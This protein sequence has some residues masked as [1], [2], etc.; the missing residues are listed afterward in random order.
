MQAT[1]WVRP[2]PPA[3]P[4]P[5]ALSN[6]LELVDAE[7]ANHDDS[8]NGHLAKG[9]HKQAEARAALVQA[10]D[11]NLAA[12]GTPKWGLLGDTVDQV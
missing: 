4:P 1:T 10:A 5:D 12:V 9:S 8:D 2:A 7:M 3:H 11:A 6:P